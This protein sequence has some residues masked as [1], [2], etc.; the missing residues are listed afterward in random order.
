VKRIGISKCVNGARR[1]PPA[2]VR[3]FDNS[4]GAKLPSPL[5]QVNLSPK[6]S[7]VPAQQN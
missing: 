1:H 3:Q 7:G 4:H 6:R 2:S 5:I